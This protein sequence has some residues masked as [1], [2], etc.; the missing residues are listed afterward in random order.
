MY[1]RR[2]NC[3]S[4]WEKSWHKRCRSLKG[5]VVSHWRQDSG[6]CYKKIINLWKIFWTLHKI[7]FYIIYMKK[8]PPSLIN[9]WVLCRWESCK[10]QC[11][12]KTATEPNPKKNMVY[13]GPYAGVDNNL[14]L[15]PLLSR[16]QHIY[17]MPE[18]T[19]TLCQS[20]LYPPVRVFGFGL[21]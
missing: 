13:V 12:W 14:P 6:H 5:Q 9:I 10:M 7:P 16:L 2:R 3:G 11:T 18:S 19:L 15:C 17:P 20:R 4:K 21:R 8:S 1:S